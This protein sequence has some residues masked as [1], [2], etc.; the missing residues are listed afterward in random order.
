MIHN[1]YCRQS[2]PIGHSHHIIS[3]YKTNVA[4]LLHIQNREISLQN[5]KRFN[6]KML[7]KVSLQS[8]H[9]TVRLYRNVCEWGWRF[10]PS[11]RCHSVRSCR[12]CLGYR[13]GVPD[14]NHHWLNVTAFTQTVYVSFQQSE[15]TSA[16][17]SN[18]LTKKSRPKNTVSTQY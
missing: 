10:G 15:T 18:K 13:L 12:C 7:E 17:T 1:F 14:T 2:I 6:Y 5:D 11:K 8:L 9:F 16:G 3:L 4:N